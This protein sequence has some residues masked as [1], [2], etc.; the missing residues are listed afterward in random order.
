MK[1]ICFIAPYLGLYSLAKGIVQENRYDNVEV[2]LGDLDEGLK[3]AKLAREAGTEIIISRGGTYTLIKKELS[4]HV[5]ELQLSALDV[6]N[7]LRHVLSRSAEIGIVGYYNIIYGYDILTEI[8]GIRLRKIRLEDNTPI[9]DRIRELARSG[10]SYFLGDTVSTR[11]C[12]ELGYP[13]ALIE[14]SPDSVRQIIEQARTV[15]DVNKRLLEKHKQYAALMDY[16]HEN[17]IAADNRGFII[18]CNRRVEELL[19]LPSDR[20]VGKSLDILENTQDILEAVKKGNPVTEVIRTF[21]KTKIVYNTVP[22]MVGGVNTGSVIVF[23]DISKL[24][25]YEH[26]IR[27]K[28]MHK[29]FQAKYQFRDIIHQSAVIEN[30]IKTA[31]KYSV[32][33]SS[34]LIEGSS[35]VG[36]ELFAQSIHNASSRRNGP[37]VAVNCAALAKSII[38]SELFG[39]AEGAFTGSKKG[40]RQGMFELAHGGTIFLD[41]ISELPADHLPF[42]QYPKQLS[43][44]FHL[45]DSKITPLNIR[46][47]SATNRDLRSMAR[48]GSFRSDLMYRINTLTLQIPSLNRR[49]EDIVP[50][51]Y[52][53]LA[54]Y[55]GYYKKRI[56][57]FTRPAL[58]YLLAYD[59][60][61]SIRELQGLVERAVVLSGGDSIGKED[62]VSEEVFLACPEADPKNPS[63]MPGLRKLTDRYI[64]QV[65][66]A[67]DRSITRASR[68][69]QV[70]RTTL[71][72]RLKQV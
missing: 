30:C 23:W 69:L 41:E 45:G 34:V 1:E 31:Q 38:E 5:M 72:R 44:N 2:L 50:L 49:R 8:L 3:H 33:D 24:Q 15:I 43:L 20:I 60:R 35:G 39:Y 21:G 40:G 61:G 6:M 56:T 46:I 68:V 18:A 13:C 53:F 37:F 27:F 10:V 48:D 66:E 26:N 64:L 14:S 19:E 62:F 47:I 29:G 55:G 57:G 9:E 65:Y 25:D 7:S 12:T 11:V 4:D 71:W 58:D 51:A 36:K 54:H 59:Y 67:E 17:V 28:L 63:P 16:V 32:S 52:H 70:N 22:I 42:L